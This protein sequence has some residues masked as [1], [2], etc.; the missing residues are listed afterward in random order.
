MHYA[1]A[2]A[3]MV[4]STVVANVFL[5][6]GAMA[7]ASQRT[8]FGLCDWR[9][10]AGL[11]FFGGSAIIYSWVLRWMPLNVAQSIAASQFV[12]V[13]VASALVLAEPIPLPRLI[14]IVLIAGGIVIVCFSNPLPPQAGAAAMSA[15]RIPR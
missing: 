9:T 4:G 6:A 1:V 3:I 13:I 10:L 5:K 14:G 12:A 11:A 2:F 15:E 8:I 7:P